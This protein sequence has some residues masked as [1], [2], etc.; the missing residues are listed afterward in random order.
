[1]FDFSKLPISHARPLVGIATGLEG[2]RCTA[3]EGINEGKLYKELNKQLTLLETSQDIHEDELMAIEQASNGFVAALEEKEEVQLR[4]DWMQCLYNVKTSLASATTSTEAD[5]LRAML[6]SVQTCPLKSEL[7][8]EI[9][10]LTVSLPPKSEPTQKSV[11]DQVMEIAIEQAGTSF[12]NLGR[13]GREHVIGEL[14]KKFGKDVPLISIKEAV[15]SLEHEVDEL[16]KIADVQT[17][18]IKLET[19]PL[20]NYSH[21]SPERKQMVAEQLLENKKWKGLASLDRLIHQLDAKLS[22]VEK[23]EELKAM[24]NHSPVILNIK[25]LDSSKILFNSL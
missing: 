5:G 13:A 20:S 16:A 9:E 25:H 17:L 2:L 11:H 3:K 21:L 6:S 24:S 12:I 1:M 8:N 10:R 19:L 14:I 7:L 18:Q 15:S 23:Q 4:I 22:A